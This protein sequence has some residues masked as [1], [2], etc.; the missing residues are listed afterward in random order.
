MKLTAPVDG[1]VQQLA[2]HTV[3]GVVTPAQ[4]LMV[5]V[6]QD[7]P[8]EVE[9]FVENKDIGFVTAGQEAEVKIETFPYTKYGV[10]HA[11]LKHVSSD[12]MQD[13]KKGLIYSSRVKLAKSSIQVE[14]KP[15]N[16]TPGMAVTVEIKTEKRRVIEYFLTP[17]MQHANES[18]RDKVR[19]AGNDRN[20]NRTYQLVLCKPSVSQGCVVAPAAFT[21]AISDGFPSRLCAA[22]LSRVRRKASLILMNSSSYAPS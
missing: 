20:G 13:D 19:G 15:V 3:G 6:P 14:N 2:I 22:C 5:I 17:L 1:S 16:L 7:D 8:L 12:A 11:E 9:A 4:Q 10:I 21:A 18:L